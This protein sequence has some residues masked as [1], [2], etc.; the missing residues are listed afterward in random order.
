MT[1]KKIRNC[2][3][4]FQLYQKT[5]PGEEMHVTGSIDS[6]GSWDVNKS[7]K[8]ITNN[9]EYP[10][11]KS[12]ENILVPQDTEIEYKY[13]IFN[14]K[15]FKCWE[16][17]ENR[18]VKIGKFCKVVIKDPGSQ[19][20][21]AISDQNLSNISNSEISK[22]ENPFNDG[23]S[24]LIAAD[25]IDL[26]NNNNDNDIIFSEINT[27]TINYEEQFILSNKKNDLIL[28]NV[29][30][31]ANK[32]SKDLNA[33]DVYDLNQDIKEC[34]EFSEFDSNIQNK[35]DIEND[36][37]IKNKINEF[38][39]INSQIFNNNLKNKKEIINNNPINTNKENENLNHDINANN[40]NKINNSKYNKNIICSFYLPIEINDNND[41]NPLSDYIYPN[42]F[43]L[44]KNN[45]NIYFIGFLKN[46]K[47]IPEKNK[48]ELYQKLKND[49][50]MFP[51]EINEDFFEK[52][53]KYFNEFLNLYIHDVQINISNIKNNDINN[54]I[55][56]IH[57]KYNEIIYNK[58]NDIAKQEKI[59]L[60]LFDY[61]F[62]FVPQI[63]KQNLG[64]KFYNDIRIQ[65]IF[66]NKI[67]SKDRLIK[68]PYYMKIIESILYSNIIIFPS[69]Y[70]CYQFLNLTKLLNEFKFNVNIDG[71][72]IITNK[73]NE[74]S[75]NYVHNVVLR[76]ENIFPDY[77]LY[78]SVY[79]ENKN[80]FKS[81]EIKQIVENI[82]KKEN[83]YLFLS[84]DDIKFLP[85]IK[86]K[87]QGFK[88][89][90]ENIFDEK[91][92]VSFIQ[93][94]TGEYTNKEKEITN[95]NHNI[96][97]NEE[98]KEI[99]TED[100]NTINIKEIS[101]LI[102]DINSSSETKIIEIVFK[103]INLQEKL[104][105]LSNCDCFIKTSGDINSA[106]NIYEFLM[107]K[108][109]SQ[110]KETNNKEFFHNK[111]DFPIVE[112]IISDQ[113]KEISGL[114]NYIYVNPY[115]IQNISLELSRAYRNLIFCHKNKNIYKQENS[116]KN[117]FNYIKKYFDIEKIVHYKFNNEKEEIIS[118]KEEII[119]EKEKL[120][121]INI[122]DIIKCYEGIIKSS[123][124]DIYKDR[125]NKIIIFNIDYFLSC[126]NDKEKE[127]NNKQK[128]YILLTNII[129]LALNHKN[130]KIVLFSDK[131]ESEL[132]VIINQYME[133]NEQK[134]ESSFLLLNN[135]IIASK[136]GYSFKKIS[137]YKKE[138]EN[139]WIKFLL[140]VE[141][142]PFSDKELFNILLS[143]KENCS[144]IKI[145]QKS[146]KI[147][148]Y[149][150]DCNK[151][152]LELYI[153]DFKNIIN[154]DDNYKNFVI[155]NKIKN[156]YCIT[157]ILNYKSLFISKIIKEMLVS[158]KRPKLILFFGFNKT[159]DILYNYLDK[160]KSLIE[161]H[162]K[163]EIFVY[164]IKLFPKDNSIFEI[165]EK[166]NNIKQ[167][168]NLF[169]N[170]NTDEIIS[171]FANF[172]D[173]ENI[174]SKSAN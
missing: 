97:I 169:Y 108:L 103:D 172:A 115:E 81:S 18:K 39:P 101:N 119:N 61:Y 137:N 35:D 166:Y 26:T 148:V 128:L 134:Y 54:L 112:Y 117:D 145:E 8:M 49:Y 165:E 25:E 94:I 1:S 102:N 95:I 34:I 170:E 20:I 84:I 29:E 21:S 75:N 32:L 16:N 23:Y 76:V 2:Y 110:E 130:I 161:N 157:N 73:H 153:E 162:L 41:I 158:G 15:K 27:N 173:L 47:N 74:I 83:H 62:L 141:E 126:K 98:K 131:E 167:H 28:P 78:K 86:I 88:S 150:D 90:I 120:L 133:E 136:G 43:Q 56:E 164:L 155:I 87:M 67:C 71:D 174:Y 99:E 50:R 127:K 123:K 24:K 77:Q 156:G 144:N 143:Y 163:D 5:S 168:N 59:L 70:N 72:I 44:Y 22:I 114:N 12:K 63:L 105:L 92:K 142:F 85:F 135:I 149:N 140:D 13:L 57:L 19:I 66:L 109:I 52:L 124:N 125:I 36:N 132:D 58:I 42:L 64:D 91:Y 118:N 17:N 106:F 111:G 107:T 10:T 146:N 89:F 48:E 40:N 100:V 33:E 6:L 9:K 7:E 60:M 154:N 14:N 160:K 30:K 147:Y 113:I 79:N 138:G 46:A 3:V 171:L 151:E 116:K 82:K 38:F 53:I 31:D 139:Q 45:P 121:K 55:E 51:V 80:E 122:N 11:W 65:Y 93:I 37:N 68:F 152:Q 104:F 69:Y 159:D 96:N 4:Q 129:L